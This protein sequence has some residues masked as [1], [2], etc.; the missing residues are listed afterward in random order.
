MASKTRSTFLKQWL[1]IR[2]GKYQSAV[3]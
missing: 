3:G 1:R 2:T